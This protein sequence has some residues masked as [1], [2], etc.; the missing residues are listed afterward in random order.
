MPGWLTRPRLW[1]IGGIAVMAAGLAL[2]WGWLTAVGAAP[3]LLGVLP[4]AIM[5]AL[6]LCM[7]RGSG[8]S[9]SA[10]SETGSREPAPT[11]HRRD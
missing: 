9:C 6:G 1:T 8:K 2:N 4:C 11:T 5:C 10:E 7:H 3:V